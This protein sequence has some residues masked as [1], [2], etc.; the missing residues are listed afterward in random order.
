MDSRSSERRN[1]GGFQSMFI[2]A[3]SQP[4]RAE[5]SREEAQVGLLPK[6]IE[7]AGEVHLHGRAASEAE[8]DE[9]WKNRGQGRRGTQVIYYYYLITPYS[10]VV[11]RVPSTTL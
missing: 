4:G 6:G 1:P 5:Q 8:K 3:A 10:T 2:G 11:P 7:A 9:D